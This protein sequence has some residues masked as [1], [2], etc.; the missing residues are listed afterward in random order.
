MAV[1]GP[2]GRGGSSTAGRP[3]RLLPHNAWVPGAYPWRSCQSRSKGGANFFFNAET[4][5]TQWQRPEPTGRAPP[6]APGPW[7]LV[8]HEGCGRVWYNPASGT[9]QH[10]LPSLPEGWELRVWQ[11][12]GHT[13]CQR[14]LFLN[15]NTGKL[16]A[17]WPRSRPVRKSRPI[18]S[19][20]GERIA[21]TS[22]GRNYREGESSEDSEEDVD[23]D[24]S[25]GG[26]QRVRIEFGTGCHS[27]TEV[28]AGCDARCSALQNVRPEDGFA[29]ASESKQCRPWL[30]ITA[31][32]VLDRKPPGAS[33]G[34]DREVA[35]VAEAVVEAGGAARQHADRI[36]DN[37]FLQE[38]AQFE[39]RHSFEVATGVSHLKWAAEG[40][41]ERPGMRSRK[42]IYDQLEPPT[43][44]FW[45]EDGDGDP[46]PLP[47]EPRPWLDDVLTGPARSRM[48]FARDADRVFKVLS[49]SDTCKTA[50][51]DQWPGHA[52]RFEDDT[53]VQLPDPKSGTTSE[54]EVPEHAPASGPL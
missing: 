21:P 13:S 20:S 26:E 11:S 41:T 33:G 22:T 44:M 3:V 42:V 47:D 9:C 16:R 5:Q 1:A 29:D 37:V 38:Q 8:E 31:G 6:R 15:T 36:I 28:L 49:V 12:N 19:E 18:C 40:D 27:L 35:D 45:P 51:R 10:K 46:P 7:C 25:S 23:S 17:T 43:D 53:P 4:E 14:L 30:T 24:Y 32:I 34:H 39:E 48:A 54:I 2:R 50:F 52:D